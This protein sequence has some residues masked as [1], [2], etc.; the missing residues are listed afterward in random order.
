KES[1]PLTKE[2]PLQNR[3]GAGDRDAPAVVVGGEVA[4]PFVCQEVH[5][6]SDS[7]RGAVSRRGKKLPE[8]RRYAKDD[9]AVAI[10]TPPGEKP[11]IGK[12]DWQSG[13]TGCDRQRVI[14]PDQVM[15]DEGRRQM[16]G[17]TARGIDILNMALDQLGERDLVQARQKR[18]FRCGQP[19]LA[20]VV[21]VG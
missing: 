6:F 10:Q 4:Q 20:A 19:R 8:F 15:L 13:H 16:D 5:R 17:P 12:N 14:A 18:L 2:Q 3:D 21:F 9:A 1:W 11:R 7:F